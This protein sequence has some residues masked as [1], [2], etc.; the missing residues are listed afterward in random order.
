MLVR[1]ESLIDESSRAR[2][3]EM[4]ASHQSLHVVYEYRRRLQSL[5]QQRMV[6]EDS[7]IE[8]LQE[9][10]HEAEKTGIEALENFARGLRGYTLRVA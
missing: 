1:H 3:N 8:A 2:L 9:W 4:L 10:C 6:G 7:L 5:W